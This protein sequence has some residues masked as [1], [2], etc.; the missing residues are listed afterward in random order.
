MKNTVKLLCYNA[1]T[2]ADASFRHYVYC[3]LVMRVILDEILNMYV[4]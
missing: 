2:S 3:A 4:K 1:N